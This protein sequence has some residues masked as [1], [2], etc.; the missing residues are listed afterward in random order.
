MAAAVQVAEVGGPEVLT[1]T[2]MDPGLPGPAE[3]RIRQ[4]AIGVNFIDVAFRSGRYPIRTPFIPGLEGAGFVEAIGE[5]VDGIR[6]GDR[7]GY[8]SRPPPG[9]YAEI[10]LLP[11]S[12]AVVLPEGLSDVTAAAFLF[13]GVTVQGLIRSCYPIRPGCTVLLHAAAGGVGSLL[14]RWAAHLGATVIGTVGG[15]AKAAIARQ[16]G[17]SHVIVLGTCDLSKEVRELTAGKGVDV[18]FDGVGTEVFSA[19]LDCLRVRG[20]MVCY[21]AASGP[22]DPIRPATLGTKGSLFLTQ[23]GMFHYTAQAAEYRERVADVLGAIGAGI[24][25]GGS[26]ATYPLAE[27]AEAHR[28]LESR[29]TSGSLVLQP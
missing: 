12:R 17:C 9:G 27:A 24:I 11:A 22:L 20:T 25:G 13:K 15:E 18:V 23:Y 29:Q 2:D 1:L 14:S 7:I 8:A 4:T 16:Q 3:L 6:V 10:R 19:S 5:G 28:A 21:G 26:V